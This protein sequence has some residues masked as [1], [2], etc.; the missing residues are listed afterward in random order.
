[1]ELHV[2][3][4]LEIKF[5][6]AFVQK[7]IRLYTLATHYI[8]TL[9]QSLYTHVPIPFHLHP[10]LLH[11]VLMLNPDPVK[12]SDL[13]VEVMSQHV[14][15][16]EELAKNLGVAPERVVEIRTQNKLHTLCCR[17]LLEEVQPDQDTLYECLIEMKYFGLVQYL[18]SG[19]TVL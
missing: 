9:I 17:K 18:E 3:N 15:H 10:K 5:G 14:F 6:L 11:V 4:F 7:N 13:Q 12:L 1:M 8:Y 19:H 16:W 2:A